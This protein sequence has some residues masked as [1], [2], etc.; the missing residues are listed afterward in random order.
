LGNPTRDD[1]STDN[2]A[3]IAKEY[4]SLYPDRVRY[5]HHQNFQNL[6]MSAARNLGID[7]AK[8]EYIA[9]LDADDVWMPDKL[10]E[11]VEIL[12]AHPTAGMVYGRS[13]MWYSW[14]DRREDRLTDYLPPLGL[15]ADRL[16]R[17]GQLSIPFL[18]DLIQSPTT[19][20]MM[21]RRE[22][23]ATIGRFENDFRGLNEDKVFIFKVLLNTPVFVADRYWAKYRQHE[24]S[25]C[26]TVNRDDRV[27]VA[28][29]VY[30]NWVKTYLTDCGVQDADLWQALRKQQ[31]R[32]R[33]RFLY[34]LSDPQE[35]AVWIG[36]RI[37]LPKS[38]RH[39]LWVT[40]SDRETV[41]I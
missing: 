37:L 8:G 21:V 9:F 33:H 35:L 30:F 12:A 16:I 4:A 6:G 34:Y 15:Q 31:I 26:A 41:R 23:F 29:E 22:V 36:R 5:L 18:Q 11:Q 27:F 40:F 39:W 13:L 3:K 24:A 10:T 1:G 28:C 17:S 19:C 14:N 2:S 20:S 25:N 32:Y 7:N 38:L